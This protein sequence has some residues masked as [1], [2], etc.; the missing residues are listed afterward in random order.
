MTDDRPAEHLAG[1]T[2]LP[3]VPEAEWASIIPGQ[4]A[5]ESTQ[6]RVTLWRDHDFWTDGRPAYFCIRP[7]CPV[8]T[9]VVTWDRLRT[10]SSIS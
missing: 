7:R 4:C 9:V 10:A 5:E 2:G 6:L 3:P 8:F 1:R